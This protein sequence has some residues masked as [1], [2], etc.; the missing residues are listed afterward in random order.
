VTIVSRMSGNINA[1]RN[2]VEAI[3]IGEIHEVDR[4]I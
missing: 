2:K 1:E 4:K 3:C